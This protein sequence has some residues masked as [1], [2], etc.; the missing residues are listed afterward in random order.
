VVADAD[1]DADA[2]AEA[3]D[4]DAGSVDDVVVDLFAR[5]RA[6]NPDDA[7]DSGGDDAAVDDAD[8]ADAVIHG[9][10]A[11]AEPADP[12]DDGAADDEP[13]GSNDAADDDAADDG[14]ADDVVIEAGADTDPDDARDGAEAESEVAVEATP[15]GQRDT[16]LTPLIVASARK[17]KRVLADEQNEVLDALRRNDP[18]RDL[19]ALLPWTTHHA[20]RY[21][22][23]LGDE[24][25]AAA[26]AGAAL[27]AEN[28]R[29][30]KLGKAAARQAVQQ[31]N[32]T[33]ARALVAP[34][35]D[36]LERCIAEGDGDNPAI[37]KKVR[38]VYRE[39][40]TQHIDEQLDDVFRAAHGRGVLAS[41][42]LGTPLDWTPD[43]G[44]D[45]CP[46]CDDN[47]LAGA[48]PAGQTF[49]TGH[50]CTPAHP[51]CRCLLVPAGR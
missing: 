29:A 19:D 26:N 4:L 49:P 17:L 8:A 21:S 12:D 43:P 20:E 23:V 16:D 39:C 36:R 45:V 51:G 22:V 14:A 40:K 2:D 41:V 42:E 18:V 3:L 50:V 1:A 27:T 35:R 15:F 6:T 31:A 9:A 32:E 34:L 11:A 47:R 28:G 5:L 24:L 7:R 30:P 33:L 38:A 46:D 44:H 13:A 37:T 10:F 48:V 25:H